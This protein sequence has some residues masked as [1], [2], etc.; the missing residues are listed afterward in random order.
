ME[1]FAEFSRENY[2]VKIFQQFTDILTIRMLYF[3]DFD[4]KPYLSHFKKMSRYNAI[5]FSVSAEKGK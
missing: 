3:I 1:M 4:I 5:H 2:R